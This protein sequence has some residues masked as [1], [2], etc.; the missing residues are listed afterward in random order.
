M[1]HASEDAPLAADSRAGSE[2]VLVMPSSPTRGSNSHALKVAGITALV[3]LL[4]SAQ[5]FTAYLVFDQ[6]QQIQGLQTNNQ[7]MERQMTLRSRGTPQ[8][9]MMPADS[10]PLLDFSSDEMTPQNTPKSES[11]KQGVAPPSV[12]KQL[13][14]LIKDHELP[15]M[16]ESFL[17]NLQTLKQRVSETD[18]KSFESWM[19]YWL[20]FQ[21]AQKPPTATS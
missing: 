1:E 4:V 17:A 5:V 3:C 6:K 21:M 20:I 11:P 7:K 2:Q 15:E 12:E 14:E 10:L 19:R 8:K 16:N 18:W 13:Q 9:I